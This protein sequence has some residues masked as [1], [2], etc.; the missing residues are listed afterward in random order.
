MN[1]QSNGG[2]TYIP[3]ASP[4]GR[5]RFQISDDQITQLTYSFADAVLDQ[6]GAAESFFRVI[7]EVRRQRV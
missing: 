4:L 2:G 1:G 3:P 6:D 5:I 7:K